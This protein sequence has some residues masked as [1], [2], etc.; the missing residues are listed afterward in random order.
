MQHQHQK[1]QKVEGDGL[2]RGVLCWLVWSFLVGPAAH[3]VMLYETRQLTPAELVATL[4]N[5]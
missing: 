1:A 4:L 3:G 5:S 2:I